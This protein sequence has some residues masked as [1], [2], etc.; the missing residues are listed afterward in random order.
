MINNYKNLLITKGGN[1]FWRKAKQRE[2]HDTDSIL[3]SLTVEF[4]KLDTRNAMTLRY[5]G[6]VLNLGSNHLQVSSAGAT[7]IKSMY[8]QKILDEQLMKVYLNYP[9]VNPRI[10]IN[11]IPMKALLMVLKELRTITFEEYT[12]FVCWIIFYNEIPLII[13]IIR[14]YRTGG[15]S[16]DYRALF[17]NKVKEIGI[18]DFG[19]NIK[20]FFDMMAL[21][22]YFTI[23]KDPSGMLHMISNLSP[24]D[25]DIV[26]GTFDDRNFAETTYEQYLTNNDGWQVYGSDYIDTL[27]S[28]KKISSEERKEL[29]EDIKTIAELPGLSEVVPQTIYLVLTG[30]VKKK[31]RSASISR[32]PSKI[33]YAAKD[34]RNR[35]YGDRGEKIVVKLEKQRLNDSNKANLADKVEQVSL[36][37]DSLGYDILSYK[38]DGVEKHIEVKSVVVEPNKSFV[39]YISSKEMAVAQLDTHYCL[40]IVFDCKST[41]PKVF[42]MPNPFIKSLPGVTITPIKHMVEVVVNT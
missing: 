25:I 11:I 34:T 32:K 17:N 20:R 23:K 12:A 29:I 3:R 36:V 24:D 4:S 40:Y 5:L 14:D 22:S 35:L 18:A 42:E 16:D 41:N 37:D 6:L 26:L 10:K 7:F 33:D 15:K 39:F 2:Y 38:D 30:G 1:D 9:A 21:S 8:K 13:E 19:D 27:A 31:L 28:L